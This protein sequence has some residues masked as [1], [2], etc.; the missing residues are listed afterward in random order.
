MKIND[1]Q[2]DIIHTIGSERNVI[3]ENVR[4][5]MLK[6]IMQGNGVIK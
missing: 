6:Q 2:N 4:K 5:E 3:T 1:K